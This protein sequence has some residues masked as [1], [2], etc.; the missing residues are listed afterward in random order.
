MVSGGNDVDP[1]RYNQP[2]RDCGRLIPVRDEQDI[3]LVKAAMTRKIPMLGICR[4]LQ[5]MAVAMGG[6]M[7]QDVQKEA[8]KGPV[9]YTHLDVYKRQSLCSGGYGNIG[10][11]CS[12]SCLWRH[13]GGAG[14]AKGDRFSGHYHGVAESHLS[15]VRLIFIKLNPKQ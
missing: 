9:S 2:V 3:L 14:T 10:S 8:E 7:Y 15:D 5:I 4:G 1:Q 13:V 6:D 11:Q 12:G